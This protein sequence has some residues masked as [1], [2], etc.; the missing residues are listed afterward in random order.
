MSNYKGTS[1]TNNVM[2]LL[3]AACAD[4]TVSRD[5]PLQMYI[6]NQHK[7]TI[8]CSG[9]NKSRPIYPCGRYAN[10]LFS[11]D[12][13]M[14]APDEKLMGWK[15][16]HA[17]GKARMKDLMYIPPLNKSSKCKLADL[18]KQFSKP[19]SKNRLIVAYSKYLHIIELKGHI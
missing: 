3:P 19:M 2:Q 11:D 15:L 7:S 10:S 8:T 17:S 16:A 9:L 13:Q 1:L 12:I 5:Y 14:W 18:Q 6:N 4:Q